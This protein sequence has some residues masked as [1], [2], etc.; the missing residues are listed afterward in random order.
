MQGQGRQTSP[1]RLRSKGIWLRI[2]ERSTFHL[3]EQDRSGYI[4]GW[5]DPELNPSERGVVHSNRE[6]LCGQVGRKGFLI[7]IAL[8]IALSGLV[9]SFTTNFFFLLMVA[10]VGTLSLSGGEVGAFF[11]IEQA[12]LPQTCEKARRRNS[13]F[14]FYNVTGKLCGSA[15]AVILLKRDV[16]HLEWPYANE[17]KK[18]IDE[19]LFGG[20][21]SSSSEKPSRLESLAQGLTDSQ[22]ETMINLS[23]YRDQFSF[24]G[25]YYAVRRWGGL[26]QRSA[27][28]EVGRVTNDVLKEHGKKG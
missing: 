14:A 27:W 4:P 13:V 3:S 6:Y 22:I 1:C 19:E 11:S 10:L 7:L 8:L 26:E 12:I 25:K 15:G 5:I 17:V 16:P 23:P 9:Y 21:L 20:R 24:K 18:K 2:S 28:E